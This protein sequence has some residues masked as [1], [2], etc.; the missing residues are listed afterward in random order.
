[1]TEDEFVASEAT[2]GVDDET[3][4]RAWRLAVAAPPLAETTVSQLTTLLRSAPSEKGV[5]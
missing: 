4:R 5:A 3:A 1:M 2:Y